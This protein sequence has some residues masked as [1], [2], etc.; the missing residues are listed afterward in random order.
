MI[1]VSEEARE[2]IPGKTFL[3]AVHGVRDGLNGI[4]A[5]P[6]SVI[7]SRKKKLSSSPWSLYTDFGDKLLSSLA[8]QEH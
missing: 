1:G 7:W 6:K 4:N 2:F 3:R 8:L 5:H